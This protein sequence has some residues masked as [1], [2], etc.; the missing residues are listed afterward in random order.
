MD[1]QTR[2]MSV[3]AETDTPDEVRGGTS[4]SV[5]SELTFTRWFRWHL[6][7]ALF[8]FFASAFGGYAVFG[9]LPIEDLTGMI[10]N[11]TTLPDFEFVP[12]MLNN[13]RALL[14]MFLGSVTGGLLSLFGLFV[15]GLVVGAVVGIVIEEA[16]WVVILAALLPHGVIEL[17]AFFMAAAIGLRIPHRLLR[18]LTGYDETPMTRV[19]ALELAVLGALMVAMIVVA[20]W[21][22][23]NVTPEVVRMVGGESILG[24]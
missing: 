7:V 19:E 15:N 6:A 14:L 8:V 12:I 22:E 3:P 11:D 4:D 17:S 5:Y 9:A 24:E 23:V 10:P 1:E 16:S 2:V 21:I 13:L 20:A 18:Y